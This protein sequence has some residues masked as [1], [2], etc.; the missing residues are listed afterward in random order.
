MTPQDLIRTI[1]DAVAED[2]QAKA[3]K[4]IAE[5]EKERCIEFSKWTDNRIFYI[6]RSYDRIGKIYDMFLKE[7]NKPQQP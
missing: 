1:L 4:A 2:D 6:K 5:Y 3:E 7:N